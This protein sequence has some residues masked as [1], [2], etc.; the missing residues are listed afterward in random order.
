RRRSRPQPM[1]RWTSV[2]C[3]DQSW[4]SPFFESCRVSTGDVNLSNVKI[5]RAPSARCQANLDVVKINLDIVKIS[6]DTRAYG[7]ES[8]K[9]ACS[10]P[11][12]RD[13][14]QSH[15]SESG[16]TGRSQAKA[17]NAVSSRRAT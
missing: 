14:A 10:Q 17:G 1:R 8:E 9:G 11:H 12:D 6:A 4:F 16:Q 15:R 13:A 2:A 5:N 7:K 3:D